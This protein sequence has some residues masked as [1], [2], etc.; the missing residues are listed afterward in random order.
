M[1]KSRQ[2]K[3]PPQSYGTSYRGADS[4]SSNPIGFN[5]DNQ[6]FGNFSSQQGL[7]AAYS[8]PPPLGTS[9]PQEDSPE[10]TALKLVLLKGKGTKG[11]GFEYKPWFTNIR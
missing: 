4:F 6:L 2:L 9:P 5:S 7:S 11:S 8:Q 3:Q 10:V 1:G